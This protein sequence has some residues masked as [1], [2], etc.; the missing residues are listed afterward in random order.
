M[1]RWIP[2]IVFLFLLL[3]LILTAC[4]GGEESPPEQPPTESPVLTNVQAARTPD[5]QRAVPPLNVPAPAP[6]RPGCGDYRLLVTVESD[7]VFAGLN[8]IVPENAI[9]RIWKLSGPGL[10]Y[11]DPPAEPYAFV[12]E[13]TLGIDANDDRQP[14]RARFLLII[15]GVAAGQNIQF[16]LGHTDPAESTTH[17]TI[18]N[19][20]NGW[21]SPGPELLSL[22]VT[23]EYQTASLNLCAAEPMSL[24]QTDGDEPLPPRLLAFFYPWWTTTA[25]ECGNDLFAWQREVNG[26]IAIVTGQTP[27]FQDG[28]E[29]IY[30]QTDCWEQISDDFGRSGWIYY[31]RDPEFFA[32]QMALAQAYGLD[33]FAVSTHGDSP[34]EMTFL[35]TAVSVANQMGFSIAPLYE[36]P[37][38]GWEYDEQA[39]IDKVGEHLREIIEIMAGQPSAV[40]ITQDGVEKV[41]VFVDVM[42]LWRFPEAEAWQEIRAIIDEAQTPYFLWSGPGEMAWV[43]EIGFDGVYNDL[44]VVE[45]EEPFANL[46]PYSLRD[47]RRL[48]YRATAWAARERGIPLALPVVLGWEGAETIAPPDYVPLPR[49]YGA[50]GD[51]G[52]YYRI[53]WEDALEQSP[54]WIVITSWNEWVE[55]TALEPSDVYPPSRF[56]YLQAT[57]EYA[58]LWRG[59]AGCE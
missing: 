14:L 52:K 11:S 6:I 10:A 9:Q 18:A 20:I 51:Y 42:T 34:T 48:M 55:G 37:E 12:D 4:A 16:E 46:P 19:T 2:L 28:D 22:D 41:V 30:R 8:V 27:I 45:T 35:E 50:P 29:V 58:C 32:E 36:A 53:R 17:I 54:D 23:Q 3:V 56:D 40:T 13:S 33:G 47:Y 1:K 21:D 44:D 24:P 25:E 26:K 7:A 15:S 57:W 43:F 39:D 5:P 59:G 38:T 31:A 49:D